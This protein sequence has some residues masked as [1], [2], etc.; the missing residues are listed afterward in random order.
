MYITCKLSRCPSC[1]KIWV[2]N[3]VFKYAVLLE[4]YAV[5]TGSR[6][7]RA[8]SSISTDRVNDGITLDDL[9]KYQRNAKSR[10]LRQGVHAG[11]NLE[12]PFRIKKSVK[13]ALCD[14]LGVHH[15]DSDSIPSGRFWDT[16]LEPSNLVKINEI[17]G[18]RFNSW[19]DCVDLSPHVHYVVFPGTAM[20]TGDKDVFIRKLTG[21]GDKVKLL[22]GVDDV[23][24]H[25]RYL[26]GHCGVLVNA[27]NCRNK[28][29]GVF[30]DLFK[31]NPLDYLTVDEYADIQ[32]SVLEVLNR[33]R[34]TPF[35]VG[36][37]GALV[38]EHEEKENLNIDDYIPI[39]DFLP[40][41]SVSREWVGSF[42]ASIQNV[43]NM[44]YVQSL[45]EYYTRLCDDP[46]IPG[47]MKRIF[48]SDLPDPPDSFKIVSLNV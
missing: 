37:D 8:I 11:F 47:K 15:H 32:K 41:D 13:S 28:P 20:F 17:L 9:R 43:D 40:Y 24:M 3:E 7:A 36:L 12:H 39:R 27:G 25:L 35:V 21:S 34:N 16:L 48:V 29:A 22:D 10:L 6:P 30:G 4:S 33:G 18:T 42:I 23:V 46:D 44:H 19:R 1:Y 31:F 2:D 14:I 26:I 45:I 38:F 5:V